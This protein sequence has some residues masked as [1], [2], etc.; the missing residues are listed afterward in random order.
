MRYAVYFTPSADHPLTRAAA[1]WLGRNPRDPHVADPALTRSSP[2]I[3]PDVVSKPARYGFH[4]TIKAPFRLA[5][6]ATDL[7]LRTTLADFTSSRRS[8]PLALRI[9]PV[10]P[11]LAMVPTGDQQQIQSIEAAIHLPL[12][13]FRAPLTQAEIARRKPETLTPLQRQMLERH[14]YPFVLDAFRFHMTLSNALPPDD[15]PRV[16]AIA[17][18]HFAD[19]LAAPLAIDRLAL[20]VEPQPDAPFML[21]EEY[22]FARTSEGVDAQ[23]LA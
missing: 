7:A 5:E 4:A 12:E 16:Q 3:A 1:S 15:L 17:Q 11:F 2:P 20:F 6:G 22:T 14:G 19:A 18:S 8:I 23:A 21:R 9:E 13:P 10:G